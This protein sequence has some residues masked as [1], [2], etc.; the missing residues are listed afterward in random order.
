M[1]EFLNGQTQDAAT[2]INSAGPPTQPYRNAAGEFNLKN[3]YGSRRVKSRK[4]LDQ[5]KDDEEP[6]RDGTLPKYGEGPLSTGGDSSDDSTKR[7]FGDFSIEAKRNVQ[8]LLKTHPMFD[9][10]GPV[11]MNRVGNNTREVMPGDA[12]KVVQNGGYL[13]RDENLP[14]ASQTKY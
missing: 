2:P 10:R 9:E 8:D 14:Q 4:D 11:R 1:D 7:Y 12:T 5:P 6:M 13:I 3:K